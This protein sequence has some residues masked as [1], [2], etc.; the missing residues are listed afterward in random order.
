MKKT[1]KVLDALKYLDNLNLSEAEKERLQE[2]LDF[3]PT[4]D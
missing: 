4:T 2:E 3:L 1:Q